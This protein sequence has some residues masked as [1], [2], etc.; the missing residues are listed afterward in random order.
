MTPGGTVIQAPI[1]TCKRPRRDLRSCLRRRDDPWS[2]SADMLKGERDSINLNEGHPGSTLCN[3]QWASSILQGFPSPHGTGKVGVRVHGDAQAGRRL[4]RIAAAASRRRDAVPFGAARNMGTSD[5]RAGTGEGLALAE[6]DP[7]LHAVLQ[8]ASAAELEE[9]SGVLF[10]DS[11]FSPVLKSVVRDT[12]PV[13]LA[14]LGRESAIRHIDSRFRFLAANSQQVLS[15]F[16]PSYR[17]ALLQV[18][19]K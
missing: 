11:P 2:S 14:Y 1:W 13:S 5:G 10:G 16:R 7:E 15:G 17:D 4:R 9:I 18:R 6:V 19:L 8:L 3:M 12:E